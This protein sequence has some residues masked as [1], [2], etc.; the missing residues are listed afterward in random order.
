[1]RGTFSFTLGPI[2]W[3]YMAE[4]IKPNIMPYGSM[5][6]WLGATLVM[7]TFPIFQE[8]L[9]NPGWIFIFNGLY[10]GLSAILNHFILV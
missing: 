6:N 10:C 4:I 3:L 9:G 7:F 1:M 5:I 8:Y 2:V